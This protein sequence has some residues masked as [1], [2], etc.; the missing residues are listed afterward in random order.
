M[1]HWP[2]IPVQWEPFDVV[3][4][5]PCMWCGRV[6]PTLYAGPYLKGSTVKEP[7]FLVCDLCCGYRPKR[8]LRLKN[9]RRAGRYPQLAGIVRRINEDHGDQ[10]TAC[11]PISATSGKTGTP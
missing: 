1:S 5:R 8:I 6:V 7:S 2:K 11:G 3:P 9:Q 4:D 10:P